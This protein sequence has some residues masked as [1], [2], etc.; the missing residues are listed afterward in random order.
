M[1]YKENFIQT[2][3][4]STETENSVELIV[5]HHTGGTY[6]SAV[7]WLTN[8]NANVSAHVVIAKDG[9]R[10]VLASPRTRTWHAGRSSYKGRNNVNDFGVG[11]EFAGD[12][13]KEPLTFKQIDSF[14]DY[15]YNHLKE[16]FPK[17][18]SNIITDHRT[19]APERKVDI[20]ESELAKVKTQFDEVIIKEFINE[21]IQTKRWL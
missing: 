5:L 10:T 18:D 6:E 14:I 12:T 4:F 2:P 16:F 9:E 17:P 7:N 3:N 20:K 1:K 15:F 11:V 13:N 19:I 8:P 21:Y